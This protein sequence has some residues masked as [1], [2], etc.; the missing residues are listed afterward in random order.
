MPLL[1]SV[2]MIPSGRTYVHYIVVYLNLSKR[3][4]ALPSNSLLRYLPYL[5]SC[6]GWAGF[7]S[8]CP[9]NP[10]VKT[11]QIKKE[12]NMNQSVVICHVMPCVMDRRMD[13]CTHGPGRIL[14]LVLVVNLF[15]LGS[16][17]RKEYYVWTLT[18]YPTN[19]LNTIHHHLHLCPV[20][21]P[22]PSPSSPT[23]RFVLVCFARTGPFA[24]PCCTGLTDWRM[25][26]WKIKSEREEGGR[27][28]GREGG[29]NRNKRN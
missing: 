6:H 8:V 14:V 2:C 27:Q 9:S 22:S 29:R 20:R 25:A 3:G 5:S 11:N 17:G 15:D 28:K 18:K 1:D 13:A 23:P 16:E 24:L 26:E 4:A 10:S 19:Q 12:I 7:L 21:S